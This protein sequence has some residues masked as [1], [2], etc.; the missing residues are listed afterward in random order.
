MR[1]RSGGQF[2]GAVDE[3]DIR[4]G[5]LNCFGRPLENK[6]VC[7]F[8]RKLRNNLRAT[9]R[10]AGSHFPSALGSAGVGERKGG[11]AFGC[12]VAADELGEHDIALL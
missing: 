9:A 4:C 1:L 6:L 10:I 11:L 5:R 8:E 2:N 12:L 3:P 7:L